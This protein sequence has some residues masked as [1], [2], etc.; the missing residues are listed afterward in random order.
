MTCPRCRSHRV[1][2]VAAGQYYCGDCCIE[3]SPGADGT[4]QVFLVDEEGE[5]TELGAGEEKMT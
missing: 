3:F 1:G 4:T 2:Q 5:L